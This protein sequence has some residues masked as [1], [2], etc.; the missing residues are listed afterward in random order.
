MHNLVLPDVKKPDHRDGD[1]LN[2]TRANLRSATRSQNAMNRRKQKGTSSRFKGVSWNKREQKWKVKIMFNCR[3][4][5]L[6]SFDSEK[7]AARTYDAAAKKYF[8]EFAKLNF[9]QN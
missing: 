8:G 4:I 3:V 2:N 1:G 5:N 6:G 7:A 9:P